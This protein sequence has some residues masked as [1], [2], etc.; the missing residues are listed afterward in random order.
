[1]YSCVYAAAQLYGVEHHLLT[2]QMNDEA[3]Q[4]EIGQQLHGLGM[5]LSVA[6]DPLL[7]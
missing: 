1:M 4:S 3:R 7:G 6:V 5:N 2:L